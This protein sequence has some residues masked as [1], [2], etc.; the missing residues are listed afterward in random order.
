MPQFALRMQGAQRSFIREILKV[1]ADPTVI[2]FAGG[3]PNPASFPVA[4]IAAAA[5]AV[6]AESGARALQYSATEG[7]LPLRQWIAHRYRAKKGMDVD[8]ADILITT[9]SQQALDL[10]AKVLVNAG[11]PV[12]IEKPGYLG[13][14]QAFSLFRPHWRSVPL[15]DDGP[16]LPALD[17][18]LAGAKLF[19]AV[20]SFQNPSGLSYSEAKR[21][22][23]AE[24]LR[25]HDCF[26][27]E[28]DPYGELRFAG[29]DL[30]PVYAQRPE[31]SLLLGTFS[32]IAAPGFRL[33]WIVARGEIMERLVIAKQAADLHTGSLDQMVVQRFLADNDFEAHVARIRKLYGG[34]CRAMQEAIARHF[35]KDVRVTAPEGGMFLWATLPEGLSSMELLQLAVERKVAFVPGAAFHVDG[36]GEDTLRL[37]YSNADSETINEGIRRLAQCLEICR[38]RRRAALDLDEAAMQRGCQD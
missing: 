5:G 37:N 17:R 36:T 35:P 4:E 22:Q 31:H 13:A 1:T 6:L 23:V 11:D 7:Y 33:G 18:A 15:L 30:P 26:F 38:A 21:A 34:Q 27:L 9:G 25:R 20:T 8:P 29:R 14:I 16:D 3:L 28:D 19:Y 12:V 2:S 10:A 24:L 32:K